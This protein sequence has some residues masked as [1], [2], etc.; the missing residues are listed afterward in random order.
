[1]VTGKTKNHLSER[2]LYRPWE[3]FH[4]VLETQSRLETMN[5]SRASISTMDDLA[6]SAQQENRR[7]LAVI[8]EI[9]VRIDET[10]P[11]GWFK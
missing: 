1:M 6:K 3:D 5:V 9:G 4:I 10:A 11:T 2:T 7:R 8:V